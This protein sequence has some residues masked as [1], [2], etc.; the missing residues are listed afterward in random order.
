M[1]IQ[2]VGTLL[3]LICY[4]ILYH[5][6]WYTSVEN[7]IYLAEVQ[8]ASKHVIMYIMCIRLC[9]VNII[10]CIS[11]VYKNEM[12]LTFH[13]NDISILIQVHKIPLY[14]LYTYDLVSKKKMT[15]CK[16]TLIVNNDIVNKSSNNY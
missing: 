1:Y 6:T 16:L 2:P 10:I 9:I 14:H 13:E 4:V 11:N 5:E 3:S 12:K 15:N 8:N 7:E